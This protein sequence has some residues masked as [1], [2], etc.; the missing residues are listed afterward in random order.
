MLDM[1]QIAF[2]S[3]CVSCGLA[4]LRNTKVNLLPYIFIPAFC[5]SYV[6]NTLNGMGYTF[7]AGLLAGLIASVLVGI[8]HRRGVHSYLFIIIPV[9]YCMGPGGAMYKLFLA[10]LNAD[11]QLVNSQL[12][13]TLKDAVGIWW[14]IMA[15]TE[16]MNRLSPKKS[17]EF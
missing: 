14:G 3:A 13:Y 1:L 8:F 12:I 16:L 11:W 7:T 5:A 6:F 9:I 15:G 2:F 17:E 10:A 4:V